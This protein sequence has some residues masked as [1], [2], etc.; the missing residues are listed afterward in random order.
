MYKWIR[1]LFLEPKDY[2][3]F[4]NLC[5][6]DNVTKW[7]YIRVCPDCL[8]ETTHQ[9]RMT[10]ICLKCGMYNKKLLTTDGAVRKI[11]YKGGWRE[12]LRIKGSYYIDKVEIEKIEKEKHY[13]SN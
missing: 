3:P 13:G 7:R 9:E 12:N 5:K 8:N 10:S 2:D 1:S 11:Y 4:E 6:G